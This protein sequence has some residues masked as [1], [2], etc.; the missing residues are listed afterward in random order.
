[1]RFTVHQVLPG[2]HHMEDPLGGVHMTLVVGNKQAL[3]MDAGY[4][5]YDVSAQVRQITDLPLT[6]ILSHGHHDHALGAMWFD[7]AFMDPRDLPV[8]RH[9]TGLVE[10]ERVIRRAGL[11]GRAAYAYR[12][13]QIPQP[14][15]LGEGP[16][17][18][19]GLTV[20]PTRVPGHTPGSVALLVQEHRLLLLGDSWNPQT[21]VFFPEA[22]PVDTY[23]ASFRRLMASPFDL[24]LAPHQAEPV[25]RDYLLAFRDGLITN[26]PAVA[27]PFVVPG[28]ERVPTLA[29]APVKGA[30]LIFRQP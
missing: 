26:G 25:S 30:R 28:H 11:T 4:G 7:E 2:V 19:G 22:L 21:W 12:S 10:R 20:L 3:M 8:L 29:C 24:A 9:Y 6:L 23:I 5:A 15:P 27:K 16:L 13:R 17:D 14:R 1:M 18:L